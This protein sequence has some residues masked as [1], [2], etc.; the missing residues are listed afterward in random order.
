MAS[1]PTIIINPVD[2]MKINKLK[3]TIN[4]YNKNIDR[5]N[6]ALLKLKIFQDQNLV[7]DK[8]VN[9]D[10]CIIA[11]SKARDRV[12]AQITQIE[13]K[14]K[15]NNQPTVQ[16]HENPCYELYINKKTKNQALINHLKTKIKKLKRSKTLMEYVMLTNNNIKYMKNIKN[17]VNKELNQVHKE[18]EHEKKQVKNAQDLKEKVKKDIAKKNELF[19][20]KKNKIY[21]NI[22]NKQAKMSAYATRKINEIKSHAD[23][24]KEQQSA[25]RSNPRTAEYYESNDFYDSTG[26]ATRKAYEYYFEENYE[27]YKHELISQ[28][29]QRADWMDPTDWAQGKYMSSEDQQYMNR[30]LEQYKKHYYDKHDIMGHYKDNYKSGTRTLAPKPGYKKPRYYTDE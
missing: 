3:L 23:A 15:T 19:N 11:N 6:N 1:K 7:K 2:Q 24:L 25:K 18:L 8:I 5:L 13:G 17:K 9:V 16:L 26:K 21:D 20:K 29:C 28:H 30:R 4:N 27:R 22:H 12:I 10:N 14:Y